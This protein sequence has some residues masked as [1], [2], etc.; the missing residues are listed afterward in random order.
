M[1]RK[2]QKEVDDNADVLRWSMQSQLSNGDSLKLDYVS[3]MFTYTHINVRQNDLN[4]LKEI[5]EGCETADQ[6]MFYQLYG[7]IPYLL[8]VPIDRNLFRALAQFWNP[9]YSCFTFG[10]VDLTS[11]I[12]EYRALIRC[13]RA[14]VDRVY[15]KPPVTPSF[16]KKLLLIIG[17]S[18]DWVVK[19]IKK[20]R[21]SE[22]FP[23]SALKEII[24]RHPDQR[25]KLDL[26]V[27]G[28]YRLVI[29]PN[30]LGYVDVL[31]V[32]LFERLDKHVDPVP[33][34]LA[35]MFRYLSSC[36]REGEGRFI[37]CAPL[38]LVWILN[39]FKHV[40]RAPGRVFLDG[41]SP[42][43]DFLSK[44]WP[45]GFTEEKWMVIFRDIRDGDVLWRASWNITSDILY[46]CGE[47]DWVPLLGSDFA[48][49]GDQ[50]KSKVKG[51]AEAWKQTHR[52]NLFTYG[53]ELS[54][55]YE[56]WRNNRVN[57]NIPMANP[58]N[59]QPVEEHLRIVPS[60]LELAKRDF[61]AERRQ[62]RTTLQKLEDERMVKDQTSSSSSKLSV[63]WRHE[64]AS[65][66]RAAGESQEELKQSRHQVRILSK[67]KSCLEQ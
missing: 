34:I 45:R 14:Q 10:R 7:D 2:V 35:E 30:V 15:T 32:D 57:D 28:I 61:E 50:Y 42:L 38:L 44:D 12:E 37:G 27:L 3:E 33:A 5:W 22:C 6:D 18:E 60:P 43:K 16:K 51:V 41:F 48:F 52:M 26:L 39:H 29:F 31:V 49:K 67:E 24:N 11:T 54:Q 62:W 59:I 21:D 4:E 13:P 9:G 40:K 36:R 58:E 63:E 55:E 19:N 46:K 17:M 20:K 1:E 53:L 64:V 8:D 66:K 65:L 25:K 23:W 47:R 56:Q